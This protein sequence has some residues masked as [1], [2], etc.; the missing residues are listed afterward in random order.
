[1][2]SVDSKAVKCWVRKLQVKRTQVRYRRKDNLRLVAILNNGI[3]KNKIL[4]RELR[5]KKRQEGKKAVVIKV[6]WVDWF[7]GW[8]VGLLADR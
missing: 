7:V 5:E 1:M 2:A 4:Y 3:E 8:L 6:G